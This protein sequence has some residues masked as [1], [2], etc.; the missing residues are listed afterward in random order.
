MKNLSPEAKVILLI[1]CAVAI[2]VIIMGLPIWIIFI[3][4]IGLA[5]YFAIKPDEGDYESDIDHFEFDKEYYSYLLKKYSIGEIYYSDRQK[6]NAEEI[7]LLTLFKLKIKNKIDIT[8]YGIVV[9]DRKKDELKDSEAYVLESISEEG[10]VKISSKLLKNKIKEELKK[11]EL[12]IQAKKS[13]NMKLTYLL[14][15]IAFVIVSY[16]V[17]G[18]VGFLF[19]KKVWVKSV[20]DVGNVIF[21]ISALPIFLFVYKNASYR[22]YIRTE[23]GE[24]LNKRLENIAKYINQYNSLKEKKE[25]EFLIWEDYIIYLALAGIHNIHDSNLYESFIKVIDIKE[26]YSLKEIFEDIL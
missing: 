16:I 17:A 15:F 18:K 2:P 8:E 1:V 14:I 13:K 12:I 10:I 4:L 5:K 21:I 23:N 20:I 24:D 6:Y 22:R 25:K 7:V 9:L 3:M 11:D 19:A 26:K